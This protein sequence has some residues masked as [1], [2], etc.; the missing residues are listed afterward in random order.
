[1]DHS[2]F[3]WDGVERR[4]HERFG[5]DFEQ[6]IWESNRRVWKL[7]SLL[8]TATE[9]L[10]LQEE[11]I[12]GQAAEIERLKECP[13]GFLDI[14][15]RLGALMWRVENG[16]DGFGDALDFCG[17]INSAFAEGKHIWINPKWE[18]KDDS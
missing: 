16:E 1:M 6:D 10:K 11:T 3:E 15:E 14:S 9:Q 2:I 7:E 5:S 4:K 8:S 17:E 13:E 12:K 18:N